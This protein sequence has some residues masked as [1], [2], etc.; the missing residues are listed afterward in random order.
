MGK[1][2]AF[3]AGEARLVDLGDPCEG[4]D[5]LRVDFDGGVQL[6]GRRAQ[7]AHVVGEDL[8]AF[9]QGLVAFGE[10]VKSFVGGH[11]CSPVLA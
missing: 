4:A 11:R 1:R 6:V 7:F 2:S 8:K 3:Q 10:P 9:G 5:V